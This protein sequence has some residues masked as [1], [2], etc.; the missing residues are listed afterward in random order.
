[1]EGGEAVSR[2]VTNVQRFMTVGELRDL[3]NSEEGRKL[4]ENA[5]IW[6]PSD[7]TGWNIDCATDATFEKVSTPED[8]YPEEMGLC[9]STKK[10]RNKEAK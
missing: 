2:T 6:V 4:N 10:M 8:G 3:L 5:F 7:D 1:M 9:I